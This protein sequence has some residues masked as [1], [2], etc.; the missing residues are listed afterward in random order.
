M[1][2]EVLL[3]ALGCGMTMLAYL[4][5]I[6]AHG[7]TRLSLS[8]LIA[9]IMLAGTVWGIVQYVNADLDTQKMAEFKRLETEKNIAEARIQSQ[10]ETLR[11]NKERMIMV[12]KLNAVVTSGTGYASTMISVDLQNRSVELETLMGRAAEM[13]K[14]TDELKEEFEK[15]ASKDT[16]F[17]EP[18]LLLK[19]AMQSLAE[20]AY[21][22]RSFYYSEDSE[23]ERVREQVL[24][25]KA[26]AAYGAFQ[27]VSARLASVGT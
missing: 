1:S 20:A 17:T 12:A 24:R 26:R 2:V 11:S 16:F 13:K 25:Q 19:D 6:N 18:Q 5:A 27:K 15:L 22:Y 3:L 10:E 14:K 4:I 21:Y 9:T 23:Q 7:S 8:Y